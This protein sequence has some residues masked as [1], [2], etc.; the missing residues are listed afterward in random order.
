[1]EWKPIQTAPKDNTIVDIW[2]KEHGRLVDYVRVDYN[3]D[4]KN[5]FYEPTMNGYSCVRD[6]T[7]WMIVEEP[8]ETH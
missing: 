8:K 2:S 5:I 1:M 6:A 4:G 3:K 7:H